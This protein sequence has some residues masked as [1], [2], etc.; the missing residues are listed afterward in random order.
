MQL[1]ESGECS[2]KQKSVLCIRMPQKATHVRRE[3]LGFARKQSRERV[4]LYVVMTNV[5]NSKAQC[6]E[7][8]HDKKEMICVHY[9]LKET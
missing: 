5:R 6:L 4:F 7:L 3:C 2:Y 1:P 9:R 8:G